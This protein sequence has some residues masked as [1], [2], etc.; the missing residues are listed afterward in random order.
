MV[1]INKSL[2]GT[3]EKAIA[4]SAQL[5]DMPGF[6]QKYMLRGDFTLG[7]AKMVDGS[8]FNP[9]KND[10]ALQNY[11]AQ[12]ANLDKSQ[13]NAVFRM[14]E[15]DS[16]CKKVAQS[17][18]ESTA[19]NEAYSTSVMQSQLQTL[20]LSE[21]DAKLA[22]QQAELIDS[23]GNYMVVSK[24]W[25]SSTG[26][27]VKEALAVALG[28]EKLANS[29]KNTQKSEEE[30]AVAT[31]EGTEAQQAQTAATWLQKFALD[32]LHTALSLAK[33]AL[34]A[35]A[36]GIVVKK[37]QEWYK[38]VTEV[39]DKLVELADDM[40]KA[41]D[42]ADELSS[43]ISDLIS[44]YEKLG[45]TDNWDTDDLETA[46]NLNEEI[47]E[48]LKGQEGVSNALLYKL[49]L[50]NGKYQDQ[51]DL[52]R[53]IQKEQLQAANGDLTD[54]KDSAG[55]V[56]K[57]TAKKKRI[58]NKSF[59]TFDSD[60]RQ[61]MDLVQS[62]FG[63]TSIDNAFSKSYQL[64]SVDFN[65][66]DSVLAYYKKLQNVLAYLEKQY[67]TTE[68]ADSKFYQGLKNELKTIKESAEAYQEASDS[69]QTNSEKLGQFDLSEYIAANNPDES[70]KSTN[71]EID[72]KIKAAEEYKNAVK[73]AEDTEEE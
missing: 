45:D 64:D 40:K 46:K 19:S 27:S 57:D 36:I 26:K 34:V 70:V 49:D 62:V 21:A 54:E 31:I 51:L 23:S 48:T 65:D 8:Q 28:Y 7:K 53:Q 73:E 16:G 52:L 14:T 69:L 72:A 5:K 35:L 18:L 66:A 25:Q 39:D 12:L 10:P 11:V 13:Q 1:D 71:S 17:L 60:E 2:D 4:A 3:L 37:I 68:L 15:L 61:M 32:A 9:K 22:L 20:G 67:S 33:Q 6:I 58:G 50:Q 30:L 63:G 56:L 44:Q 47:V 29:V 41:G 43:S 24:D 38:S 59:V 55:D 42:K